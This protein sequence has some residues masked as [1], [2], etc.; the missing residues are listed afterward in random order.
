MKSKIIP[1]NRKDLYLIIK[2]EI[3]LS[4]KECNLNHIDVSSITDFSCLFWN[5]EFNGDISKWDVS[6]ASNM[7]SMF[8]NAKFKGD[9]SNWKPYN[10]KDFD[11]FLFRCDSKNPYWAIIENKD[12]R[13]KAID[14]YWLHSEL[15]TI[16]NI[17]NSHKKK[18]KI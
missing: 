6:N 13:N 9:L 10:L 1:K 18:I 14:N 3:E 8:E 12:K 17:N 16:L 2:K 5:S 4:G 11:G 15:D 7:V